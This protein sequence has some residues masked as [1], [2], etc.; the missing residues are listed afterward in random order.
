MK[1]FGITFL[2]LPRSDEAGTAVESP[3]AMLVPQGFLAALC[4]ADRYGEVYSVEI[5][6]TPTDLP[7]VHSAVEWLQFIQAQCPE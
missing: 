4:V 2:A 5:A 6:T 3:A 7:S 1:A